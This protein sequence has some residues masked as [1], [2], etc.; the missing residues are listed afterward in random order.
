MGG[1]L[2]FELAFAFGST[3]L[4]RAAPPP[5]PATLSYYMGSVD[6]TAAYNLGCTLGSG[7]AATPGTQ[8]RLA[9]LDFGQP[10]HVDDPIVGRVYG[11]T[12]FNQSKTFASTYQIRAA[13]KEFAH[14]YWWCT[15]SDVTSKVVVAI[16]TS[17][18]RSLADPGFINVTSVHGSNWATLVNQVQ[19]DII[20]S[21]WSSQS[22]AEGA[23]DMELDWNTPAATRAWIN[24]FAGSA[25]GRLVYNFGDAA[26][27]PPAGG[28][29][30][31][32]WTQEDLWFVSWGALPAFP[33][34]EV[35]V[36]A[37]AQQWQAVSLFAKTNHVYAMSMKGALAQYARCACTNTPAAAWSQLFDA[38][39]SDAKTAQPSLRWSADIR[40]QL[41]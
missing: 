34:P 9:I 26:G 30:N 13:A 22:S 21:G 36:Q 25:A 4:V 3:P 2:I 8:D 29:C 33:F 17:N 20:S 27:C 24:G 41:P 38:L 12:L 23:S 28:V 5:P 15:G 11:S 40:F 16:G 10:W 18:L 32:G 1:L 7:D 31:N 39:A 37:M 14:G 35:Y 6:P 19:S